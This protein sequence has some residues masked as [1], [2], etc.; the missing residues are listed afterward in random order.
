MNKGQ[1]AIVGAILLTIMVLIGIILFFGQV[2]D[3]LKKEGGKTIF[4]Q[5]KSK[6]FEI[7][8]VLT[9]LIRFKG[10]RYI[11]YDLPNTIFYYYSRGNTTILAIKTDINSD[12][13]DLEHLTDDKI[14]YEICKIQ[15]DDLL[16]CYLQGLKIQNL[17]KFCVTYFSDLKKEGNIFYCFNQRI[18]E[19]KNI[20]GNLFLV[21]VFPTPR[22]NLQ[23]NNNLCNSYLINLEG[24]KQVIFI[25]DFFINN[26]D[27][28]FPEFLGSF[29]AYPK[30]G[31]VVKVKFKY[32][33]I[34]KID[35]FYPFCENSYLFKIRV[36]KS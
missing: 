20:G 25:C 24:K 5:L 10:E 13:V 15:G 21:S 11:T 28:Y 31:E 34:E 23:S 32:V 17:S 16:G 18:Y 19:I 22:I 9:D 26:N 8:K 12:L 3:L 29:V 30:E 33:G 7:S 1:A 6:S 14:Y 27:C 4:P 36:L 35:N 2:E